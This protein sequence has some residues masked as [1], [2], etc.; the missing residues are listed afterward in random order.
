L[1]APA[2]FLALLVAAVGLLP[3]VQISAYPTA[4]VVAT[5][6]RTRP[7]RSCAI[8]ASLAGFLAARER[9]PWCR[10]LRTSCAATGASG[11]VAG[12]RTVHRLHR[13][14]HRLPQE[15]P[16]FRGDSPVVLILGRLEQHR[17]RRRRA[18]A[19]LPLL[20]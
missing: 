12:G 18:G 8:V 1:A 4:R 20:L 3:G 13:N 14:L 19:V 7:R 15:A 6:E 10:L 2:G 16:D 5:G 17:Q 9:G 11:A